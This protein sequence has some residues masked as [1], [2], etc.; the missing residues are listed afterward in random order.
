MGQIS[1]SKAEAY[2]KRV[3]ERKNDKEMKKNPSY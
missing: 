3:K 1:Q 2:N